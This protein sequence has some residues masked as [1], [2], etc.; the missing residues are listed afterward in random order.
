MTNERDI[1]L[2]LAKQL[3]L[4]DR[5]RRELVS[6]KEAVSGGKIMSHKSI[7]P[8]DNDVAN[9][10]RKYYICPEPTYTMVPEKQ[11]PIDIKDIRK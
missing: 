4:L 8:R 11:L 6:L 5:I 3:E 1:T 10:L 2:L 7:V 9:L